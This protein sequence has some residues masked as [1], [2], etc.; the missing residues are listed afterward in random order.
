MKIKR[1]IALVMLTAMAFTL[2]SCSF[3]LSKKIPDQDT[4]HSVITL[5]NTRTTIVT[6]LPEDCEYTFDED[7]HTILDGNGNYAGYIT[8]D[9]GETWINMKQDLLSSETVRKLIAESKLKTGQDYISVNYN[10]GEVYNALI[11]INVSTC[12][13][14]DCENESTLAEL[15]DTISVKSYR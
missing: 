11:R 4:K 5:V 7:N 14:L 9:M 13:W 2:S 12:L 10:D 3:L 1:I 8:S 15:L 6:I